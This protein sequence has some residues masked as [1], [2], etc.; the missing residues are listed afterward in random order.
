MLLNCQRT[1]QR[2]FP[3]RD[4]VTCTVLL[5][6]TNTSTAHAQDVA[7]HVL[8]PP[9]VGVGQLIDAVDANVTVTTDPATGITFKVRHGC[10]IIV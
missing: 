8:T 5:R 7:V 3:C 10:V 2:I 9:Y 1:A 4:N 6:S